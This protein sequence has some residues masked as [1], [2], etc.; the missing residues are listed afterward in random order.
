M[1]SINISLL[2]IM[3]PSHIA[4]GFFINI[5][6]QR[7]WTTRSHASR[8]HQFYSCKYCSVDFSLF[9]NIRCCTNSLLSCIHVNTTLLLN[10]TST[11]VATKGVIFR[12]FRVHI[13]LFITHSKKK[14]FFLS[15]YFL[16]WNNVSTLL[17][18]IILDGK[19]EEGPTSGQGM[20]ILTSCSWQLADLMSDSMLW[21]FGLTAEYG[22]FWPVAEFWTGN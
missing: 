19:V 8:Y 6:H 12:E 10:I 14:H 17:D 18:A 16:K 9:H 11:L 2:V 22:N 7:V 13:V 15:F 21:W 3:F 20:K 4:W 1:F 5:N